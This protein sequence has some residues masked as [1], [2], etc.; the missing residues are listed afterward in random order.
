MAAGRSLKVSEYKARIGRPA[1]SDSMLVPLPSIVIVVATI[2]S[3]EIATATSR[4]TSKYIKQSHHDEL[5]P[6]VLIAL[7]RQIKQQRAV[8]FFVYLLI[9]NC[10]DRHWKAH[11]GCMIT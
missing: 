4:R 1:V 8:V 11:R 6:S 10:Y 7:F 2:A 9:C 5:P 3:A